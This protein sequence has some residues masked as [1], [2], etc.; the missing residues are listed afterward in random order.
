MATRRLC[1]ALFW[2]TGVTVSVR[3]RLPLKMHFLDQG[4]ADQHTGAELEAKAALLY[5]KA[6]D[7]GLFE[8][9]PAGVELELGAEDAGLAELLVDQEDETAEEANARTKALIRR[10]EGENRLRF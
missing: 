8:T 1:S 3:D 9:G 2:T 6:N 10:E 7:Q 5:T 4:V